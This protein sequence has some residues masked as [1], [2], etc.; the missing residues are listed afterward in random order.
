MPTQ[1]FVGREPDADFCE[2]LATESLSFDSYSAALVI[3]DILR[4]RHSTTRRHFR[5]QAELSNSFKAAARL[6]VNLTDG[7]GYL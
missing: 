7:L 1:N 2:L 4:Q 3:E 6:L 5:L